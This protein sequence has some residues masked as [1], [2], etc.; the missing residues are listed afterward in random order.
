M[1]IHCMQDRERR[2]S[3]SRKT[4]ESQR[5][6]FAQSGTRALTSQ[7]D[8]LKGAGGGRGRGGGGDV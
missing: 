3:E 4:V 7:P 8:Y 6:A 1:C 5:R 2:I